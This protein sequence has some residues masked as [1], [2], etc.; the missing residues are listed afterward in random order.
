MSA[1]RPVVWG[2][3]VLTATVLAGCANQPRALHM[4]ERSGDRA[5]ALEQHDI[6]LAEYAELVERAPSV[7]EY[8][9]KYG[10]ALLHA[11]D[12]RGAREQ[13]EY[14]YTLMPRN[15]E[16]ITLLARSMAESRDTENAVRLL[17][18]IAEDRKQPEDW[19]RLGRFLA[20]VNDPDAAEAA[21]LTA[22]RIDAGASFQ[23]QWELATLYRSIGAD[24]KA[25]ERLRMCLYLD[26]ANE[27]V[28]D[29][30]RG[31]GEI[32]G[33]TA[34]QRPMEQYSVPR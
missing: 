5:T 16:V 2:T 29:L 21:L 27:E 34:A 1:R 4:V 10:R 8:R 28:R 22:A 26:P 17:R 25:L 23:P 9:L 30:I 14:A 31:Y 19:M 6:A 32:P 24:D 7:P 12:A 33:P 3:V 18:T 13:L 11:G 15:E 20:R